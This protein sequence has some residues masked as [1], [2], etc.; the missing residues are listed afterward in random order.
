MLAG[1]LSSRRCGVFGLGGGSAQPV[2]SGADSATGSAAASNSSAHACSSDN[3]SVGEGRTAKDMGHSMAVFLYSIHPLL[4]A[5][6]G[7]TSGNG[8]HVPPII[9]LPKT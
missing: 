3:C 5:F 6:P 8:R 4:Q 1:G 7:K 2:G 9:Y